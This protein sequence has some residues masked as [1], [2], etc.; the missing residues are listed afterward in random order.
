MET[1]TKNTES[2]FQLPEAQLWFDGLIAQ[3]RK[4]QLLL[5]TNCAPK[6]KE[7]FY[8]NVIFGSSLELAGTS[9]KQSSQV[10]ITHIVME[11]ID[12]LN[13]RER[14]PLKL[15]INFSDASVLVWA[16][17]KDDDEQ[18]ENALILSEAVINARYFKYGFHISS[19]I[20]EESDN[21][22]I[23]SHYQVLL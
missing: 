20:L 21:Y 9:R 23:P 14:K 17:I 13:A 22:P 16:V 18:T 12:E 15:A 2:I 8:K 10:F 4:D 7:D 3:I 1:E 11:Y 5:E 6:S 19:T